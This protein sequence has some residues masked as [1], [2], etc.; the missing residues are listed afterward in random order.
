MLHVLST[1]CGSIFVVATVLFHSTSFSDLAV[2]GCMI[3]YTDVNCPNTKCEGCPLTPNVGAG[4]RD[5]FSSLMG[6]ECYSS[7]APSTSQQ[8][9]S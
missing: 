5:P 8:W 7:I 3:Q 4:E 6:T 1:C 9:P 2:K